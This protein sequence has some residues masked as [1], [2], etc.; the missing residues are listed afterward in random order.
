VLGLGRDPQA[1]INDLLRVGGQIT[2]PLDVRNIGYW[3]KL[4]LDDPTTTGSD[5][6]THTF[7]SGSTSLPSAAIEIGH[8]DVPAFFLLKG[9]RADS[10]AITLDR[11]GKPVAVFNLVGQN[12]VKA[13]TTVDG[14]P[15]SLVLTRFNQVQGD[16]QRNAAAL[17]NVNNA[18]VT[19]RNNLEPV[20]TIRADNLVEDADAGQAAFDGS[21]STR[22]AS[23]TLYDDAVAD[24]PI[25]LDLIYT[26]DASN[27]LTLAGQEIHLERNKPSVDGSGGISQDFNFQGA[28]DSGEGEMLEVV[29]INDV[30]SYA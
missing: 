5:P 21:L 22:F 20:E 29:L 30:S 12:E 15:T 25:D 11:T 24:T 10:M 26:I 7:V 8:P 3:L 1:P 28:D 27:K 14:S 23:T 2:V 19:Y 4:L 6:Y 13:A 18:S 17:A 16:I 9:V